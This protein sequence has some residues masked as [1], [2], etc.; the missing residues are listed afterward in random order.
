MVPIL[1]GGNMQNILKF[2]KCENIK[3]VVYKMK[4]YDSNQ[5]IQE[6]KELMTLLNKIEI[7]NK[8]LTKII[9]K[10][11][12]FKYLMSDIGFKNREEFKVL[13]LNNNNELLEE[14]TLFKGTVN[15]TLIYP[16]IIIE[17]ALKYATTGVIFAHNHPS[18]NLMPSKQ[19]IELT[20]E[21][22]ELLRKI[23][24][25]L[26]EHIIVGENEYFSFL[27]EGMIG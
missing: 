19:D 17:K 5:E 16:R 1:I 15:K 21:L 10:K 9:N 13:Y 27:E 4:S 18:G 6:F 14:E 24:I 12:L 3:E 25:T 26:L 8:D 22:E 23:N 11:N 2:L 20:N 7:K